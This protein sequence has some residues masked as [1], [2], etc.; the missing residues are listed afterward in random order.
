MNHVLAAMAA[1]V[2]L[3]GPAA[4]AEKALPHPAKGSLTVEG[5]LTDIGC[6]LVHGAKGERHAR[7][8]Q[9]CVTGGAPLGVVG[10][11]DQAYLLIAD[12]GNEKAVLDARA[13][14]GARARITGRVVRKA[15]MQAL[16]VSKTE[17]Q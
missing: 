3:A 7:C 13:L 16:V 12:N 9:A 11:G 14:A 4:A 15:G 5:E 8:A 6:F 1:A 17:K 10:K 2:L